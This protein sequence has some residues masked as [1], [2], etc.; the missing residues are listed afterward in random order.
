MTAMSSSETL[1][2]P[3][4]VQ[5]DG[6]I[7]LEVAHP[8]YQQVRDQ[9]LHFADLVK[10]PEHFHTYRIGALSLWQAASVGQ[11][12]EGVL[13]VLHEHSRYSLPL[14]LQQMVLAE[15][16]KY[17][18]L[19]LIPGDGCHILQGDRDLLA[20][21]RHLPGMAAHL[22]GKRRVELQIKESA[23]GSVKRLLA[24]YGYPVLDRIGHVQGERL[25]IALRKKTL[26]GN[27]F[28]LRSYQQE[29]IESFS[30]GGIGE[31]SG[32]IV[33]PC[34]AGKTVVGIGVI[35]KLQTNTLVLTPNVLAARQW[36]REL[37]DKT[38][39]SPDQVGEYTAEKKDVRPITVTTY[40]MLTYRKGEEHPH[41]AQLNGCGWGL[42]IYDEV[43]LLP[44]PIF[45]LTAD[46]QSTRRLGLTATLVREDGAEH[47]VFAMIG[48][49]R[50]EVPWKAMEADGYLAQ[51]RCYE[52]QVKMSGEWQARYELAAKRQ[53]YRLA[54][55][56]PAKVEVILSL[57]QKHRGDR[58]LIIGQYLE[59]L[60]D[61][62]TRLGV[63][64]VTG[65]TKLEARE[66]QFRRF[67][68]GQSSVLIVSKVANVALDLPD[69]NVAIQIS[70][71]FGSRQ[72]E[73]QRIGRILRPNSDRSESHFYT[74]VTRGTV[75]CE[76]ADRRQLFLT[77]QGYSYRLLDA[78][79]ICLA[80]W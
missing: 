64:V 21:I 51:A 78:E 37:L 42:I 4:I 25:S 44:A 52:V 67:R 18:S 50:Y 69:A 27:A 1:R 2:K 36:I 54:S 24:S 61:L 76:M 38:N 35:A 55:L 72:E 74:V 57:L 53:K 41:F 14:A 56:N 60:H 15:M 3:L 6:T 22:S 75:D 77:E 71:T 80:K 65:R 49:K 7:L 46:V 9:L 59:Q 26:T 12:P 8:R 45:R 79:E 28:L 10:S 43:H 20:A 30:A 40:Q 17:G 48:P 63:P 13:S 68:E 5:S 33:L 32:V 16:N 58:V 73:A 19:I 62:A 29:A 34:G 70:G 23:R 39:V 11:S 66:E 47:D 31:G